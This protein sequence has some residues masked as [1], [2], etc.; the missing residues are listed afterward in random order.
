VGAPTRPPTRPCAV[1]RVPRRVATYPA[2][3]REGGEEEAEDFGGERPMDSG[4]FLQRMEYE[5]GLQLVWLCLLVLG[6]ISY[7]M[8]NGAAGLTGL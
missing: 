6:D 8:T 4:L 5:I 2:R 3:R 7:E 1:C